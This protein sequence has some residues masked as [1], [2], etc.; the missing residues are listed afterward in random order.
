M[1]SDATKVINTTNLSFIIKKHRIVLS[2]KQSLKLLITVGYICL[3]KG[4]IGRDGNTLEN[5]LGKA[6]S[7]GTRWLQEGLDLL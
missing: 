6:S 1:L 4:T 2:L 3:H 7:W 5:S